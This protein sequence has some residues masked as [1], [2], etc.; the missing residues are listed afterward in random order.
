MND[1]TVRDERAR[2]QAVIDTAI[3]YIAI[4]GDPYYDDEEDGIG[5]HAW[6]A[7][8]EAVNVY[9]GGTP[10]TPGTCGCVMTPP[11][12]ARM[13]QVVAAAQQVVAAQQPQG[14]VLQRLAD[15]VQALDVEMRV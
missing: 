15:A 13:W 10:A 11:A 5:L 9:I 4:T 3:T 7:L 12:M 14:D 8:A 2:R 1:N 6:T